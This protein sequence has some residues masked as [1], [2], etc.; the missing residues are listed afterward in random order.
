MKTG[1]PPRLDGRTINYSVTEKQ[2][3]DKTTVSFSYMTKKKI[4]DQRSCFIAYTSPE[5]HKIL[6]KGLL[7][8]ILS[9]FPFRD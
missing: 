7:K 9:P 1:T 8:V 5:V 6:I 4:K 3:G 2:T